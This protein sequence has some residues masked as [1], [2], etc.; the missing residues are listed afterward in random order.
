MIDLL[1]HLHPFLVHFPIGILVIACVMIWMQAIRKVETQSSISALLLL[2]AIAAIMASISGFILSNSG[3]YEK[4]DVLAH[5]WWGIGTTL[6]ALGLYFFQAYQKIISLILFVA[7]AISGH[8][9]GEL[10]YGSNYFFARKKTV[11]P[12]KELSLSIVDTIQQKIE[13]DTAVEVL[14]TA[15]NFPFEQEVLPILKSH[16]FQCHSSKKQKGKL[17]LDTEAFIK[18]GGKEGPIL[19]AGNPLKSHLYSYLILPEDDDLHMPPE[20]KKQLN[21]RQMAIIKRW[22]EMGA[23]FSESIHA[24]SLPSNAAD[25]MHASDIQS[26]ALDINQPTMTLLPLESAKHADILQA[27]SQGLSISPF[28]NHPAGLSLNF[29][30]VKHLDSKAW[31]ATKKIQNNVLQIKLTKR[32]DIQVGE[33]LNFKNLQQ[34]N[35]EQSNIQDADLE[36]LGQLPHL[37]QLNLYGTG[38]SDQGIK[39]IVAMKAL[40]VLYIWQSRLSQEG[41]QALKKARPDLSIVEGKFQFSPPDTN[42]LKA[43]K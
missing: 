34:L 32:Q 36:R 43:I 12:S 20:G 42:R 19:L 2:G 23:P 22:I 7:L 15:G 28:A 5:Q 6:C 9:G 16:C 37:A 11:Y 3:D 24:L 38:I 35:L 33:L 14:S 1:G 39:A 4:G 8:L 41:L 17:R 10:T 31:Q 21:E 29:V 26:H 30:N 27:K 25:S 18:K 13:L 40:K